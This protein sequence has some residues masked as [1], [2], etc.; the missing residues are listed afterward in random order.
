MVSFLPPHTFPDDDTFKRALQS[1][2][3]RLSITVC[4]DPGTLH[5]DVWGMLSDTYALSPETWRAVTCALA[6]HD[7][8]DLGVPH[9]WLRWSDAVGEIHRARN[10]ALVE[11]RHLL[12]QFRVGI[13]VAI[14]AAERG[15]GG[16]ICAD[17]LREAALRLGGAA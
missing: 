8:R 12:G 10:I 4:P 9:P 13:E 11:V 3:Q 7:L 2:C 1:A 5:P 14:I 6:P 16:W 17:D 15:A